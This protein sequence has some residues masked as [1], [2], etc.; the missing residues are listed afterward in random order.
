MTKLLYFDDN[1]LQEFDAVVTA[2]DGNDV[3]LDQTAFYAT[4]GGQPND[5][6]KLIC[7]GKEYAVSDVKKSQIGPLHV[8]SEPGLKMGDK[9]HG[10]IDWKRRYKLMRMHSAAHVLAETVHKIAGAFVNGKQLDLQQSKIDFTLEVFDRTQIQQ[11]AEEAN[12]FVA[13][14]APVKMYNMKR[15]EVLKIPGMVKL[16]ERLPPNITEWRIVEIVG[17]DK[18]PCGGT[19]VKDIKEI[20]TIK[21]VKA[22]NKGKTK[23]RMYYTLE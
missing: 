14:G 22:E 16:A 4:G 23:R 8:V 5:T 21:A 15:A 6:G 18:Q 13:A 9:V 2:V 17:V 1:Y 20:G 10:V 11:F 3:V 12:K 7:D 19:H